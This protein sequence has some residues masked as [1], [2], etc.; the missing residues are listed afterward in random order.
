VS[1][2]YRYSSS[3][4]FQPQLV[5]ELGYGRAI[6]HIL[7]HVAETAKKLKTPP[8]PAQVDA[9]FQEAFYLP[10]ANNAAFD[11]LLKRARSLVDKYLADYSADLLRIL[12]R[13]RVY[14]REHTFAG[15]KYAELIH[16]FDVDY[17]YGKRRARASP[18]AVQL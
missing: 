12:E 2:A 17:V 3:L 1:R 18:I 14:H 8:S 13:L 15:R 9:I 5:T 10:F 4:G 6:H 11:S 16:K 7:R